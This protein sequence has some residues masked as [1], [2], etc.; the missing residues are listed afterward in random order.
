M[1]MTGLK[2][3]SLLFLLVAFAAGLLPNSCG[4]C[5]CDITEKPDDEYYRMP[6]TETL[7]NREGRKTTL[8]LP[9]A[10]VAMLI[11]CIYVIRRKEMINGHIQH[12]DTSK[13][14]IRSVY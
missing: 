9:G 12:Q 13:G 6:I 8:L 10:A 2:R 11:V 14:S 1:E 3:A 7:P 4:G 5:G